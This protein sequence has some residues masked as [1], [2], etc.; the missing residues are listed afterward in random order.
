MSQISTL[1]DQALRT[2]RFLLDLGH[3]KDDVLSNQLIPAELREWVANRLEEESNKTFER[4]RV[5]SSTE[6][7]HDWLLSVDRSEWYYWKTLRSYLLGYKGWSKDTVLS[8]DDASDRIL[9][10]LKPPSTA[11]FDIRGLVLGYV[12]SGKTANFT[13]VI[14]KAADAGYRLIVVFS[15]I[16]N[17]LRRQ[18]QLR[19]NRELTGYPTNPRGAVR[20]PPVGRQWHQFTS[21]DLD[22]DFSIGRANHAAL[23]GSQPVLLVIKKNGAVLRRLKAWFDSAPPEVRLTLPALFIDDEADQASVDTRGSYQ[24]QAAFDA[25]NPDYE[26]PAVINGLIRSLISIFSRRAYVAYTATPFANILIP[27]N[28]YD[29]AVGSDLYPKDFF[30][31]LPKPPGYFGTEEFFGRFD[32]NGNE[33]VSGLDVVRIIPAKEVVSLLQD[34]LLPASLNLSLFAFVLGG[35]ARAKRGKG[36][37]PSTMLVHTSQRIADQAPTKKLI[38]NRFREIKDL[39]RYD[40]NGGIRE[41]LKVLWEED[42]IPTSSGIPDAPV[43]TFMDIEPF[44]GPFMEAVVVR[45]INSD[46][47]EVLD[48]ER[49]PSLKAIAVGGNR[50]AR[51]LTLEGLLVSFFARRSPQYDTL[52]QMARWYGYRAGYEDLTRIYTTSELAGWFTD[53]AL[54]EY[55]LRQDMQVYEQIPGLKP[56]EL[57]MRILQHP[58]MQVTSALKRRTGVATIISQSYSLQL[59][60]TFKFPLQDEAR[61]ALICE[62]NRQATKS[63]LQRLGG[64]DKKTKFGPVWS[65]VSAAEIVKFIRGF[66]T[67]I[68]VSSFSSELIAAWIERQNLSGDLVSWT[69]AVRGRDEEDKELGRASWLP[70]D[71]P[72]VWNISRTRIRGTNSLGVITTPGDEAIGL[73]DLEVIAADAKMASGEHRDRNRAARYSRSSQKALLL[74]YPISKKSGHD[75]AALAKGRESLYKD[76]SNSLARDLI[77]LAISF[78]KTKTDGPSEAYLEGSAR[79]RPCI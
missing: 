9:R 28:T 78:P 1:Q 43:D 39:W 68:E 62:E 22:G 46:T 13:A 54:V 2:A 34:N 5:I 76:P 16:D 45:E 36:D 69:V 55:R 51:G 33:S 30:I 23:Q 40:R 38:E 41:G 73:T 60:Q 7:L 11:E 48:F 57:G 21:D 6:E 75:P 47:G 24:T 64:S 4:A 20:L 71:E 77:G 56:S 63:F 44:I 19:L 37:A 17:G 12:Q 10:E 31:D 18:T 35:A 74:I 25:D 15:G 66:S 72:A 53:L 61:L 70:N 49:E 50:L 8:L 32:S 59:E 14:A 67:D 26:A 29:G 27:H 42:F 65:E 79:W 3:S 58:S 52:L